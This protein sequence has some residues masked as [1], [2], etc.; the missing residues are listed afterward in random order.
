MIPRAIAHAAPSF[1]PTV[2]GGFTRAL[3]TSAVVAQTALSALVGIGAPAAHAADTD[4]PARIMLKTHSIYVLDDSEWGTA[5]L[6]YTVSIQRRSPACGGLCPND[7]F[8]Y[9][10]SFDGDKGTTK[11][12]DGALDQL[13]PTYRTQPPEIFVAPQ[14]GLAMFPGDDLVVKWK[15]VEDDPGFDDYLGSVE[16]AH[17]Y[18]QRW[19]LDTVHEKWTNDIL[20]QGGFKATYEIVRA[21]LPDLTVPSIRVGNFAD[22]GDDIVCVTVANQGPEP[23]SAYT[24][25]F[26]VDGSPPPNGVIAE[27][28]VLPGGG[29]RERCFQTT[30]AAGQH[31]FT[32]AVDEDQKIPEMNEF[33]NRASQTATIQLRAAP[34]T[35]PSTSS[36]TTD[37]D[38][39]A[40]LVAA[41]IQVKGTNAGASS[42]CKPGKSDVLVQI[43]NQGDA[44]AAGFALSLLVGDDE[45]EVVKRSLTALAKGQQREVVF[46]DVK[47][48]KGSHQLTV[49][50]DVEDK[51]AESNE[52][53]NQLGQ[54]VSCKDQ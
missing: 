25:R 49:L 41:S 44:D 53:N 26:Y 16:T 9:T 21:P 36:A 33:N 37:S 46:E 40:D 43:K 23:A 10:Y 20:G 32:A 24:V 18:V 3:L 29:Q 12:F 51:V 1:T 14:A 52:S 2:P 22:N 17:T 45:D 34:G 13:V 48:K 42:S 4:P 27:A 8:E 35:A 7:R 50:V 15:G 38:T 11:S 39:G 31:Q 6:R 28:G 30:I 5:E 47:L 54:T 19:G